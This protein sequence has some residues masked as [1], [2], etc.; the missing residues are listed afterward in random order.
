MEPIAVWVRRKDEWCLIHRCLACGA[1]SSNRVA[2]DDQELVLLFIAARPL[3]R[4]PFPIMVKPEGG[5]P[6]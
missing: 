1:L 3:R 5:I 2:A 4:P 6:P